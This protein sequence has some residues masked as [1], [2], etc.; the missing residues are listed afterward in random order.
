MRNPALKV[1]VADPRR[2]DTA[3]DADLFLPGMLVGKILRSSLA[4]G[5]GLFSFYF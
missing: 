5:I 3:R 4:G 1:I 2:T